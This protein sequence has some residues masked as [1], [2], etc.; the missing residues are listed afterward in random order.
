MK[1]LRARAHPERP[2][3]VARP[4]RRFR[5]EAGVA[6]NSDVETY[7]AL[8]FE[9]DS[10]RGRR[11]VLRAHRQAPAVTATEVLATV[12]RPRSACSTS[13]CRRAPITCASGSGRIAWR[14]R[15]AP[16]S[17][18]RAR[19]WPARRSNVR[20]QFARRRDDAVRAAAGR[21]DARRPDA[22]RAAG[23]RRDR[24][25]T[26]W[27][28]CSASGRA[29]EPYAPG[30]WGPVTADRMLERHGGWYDPPADGARRA[31]RSVRRTLQRRR[32]SRRTKSPTPA[33]RAVAARG[34]AVIAVSGGETPWLILEHLRTRDLPWDRV[35]VA[36]VTNAW[37][38]EAI[39]PQPHPDWNESSST[40]ARCRADSCWRCRRRDGPRRGRDGVSAAPR[41]GRRPAAHARPSCNSARHRRPHGL[42]GA[43]TRCSRSSDREVATSLPYQ[44][45]PAHDPHLPRPGPRA[46]EALARDGCRKSRKPGG[47]LAGDPASDAPASR[48]SRADAVVV[49]DEPALACHPASE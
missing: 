40:R 43:A 34:H 18:R 31:V 48:V 3:F 21:R 10:W 37:R 41:N 45:Q 30:S 14:S 33:A 4:V 26:S 19:P 28:A 49:A 46:A 12:R 5:S 20:L 27:T 23:F 25:A 29:G 42:A 47:L 24:L 15:S 11:A 38:R 2:T 9:I 7:A 32:R 36:Q 35:H 6:G 16:A 22:V 44:G 39:Q 1:V 17:S 8:R 13:R